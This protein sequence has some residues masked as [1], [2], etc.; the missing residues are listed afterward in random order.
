MAEAFSR[1]LGY[2]PVMDPDFAADMEEIVRSRKL[3]DRSAWDEPQ[4]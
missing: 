1:E 2:K 3:A 4:D